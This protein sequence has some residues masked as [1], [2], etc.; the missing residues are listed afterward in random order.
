MENET[1]TELV[2]ELPV[3]IKRHDDLRDECMMHILRLS[4]KLTANYY[5][6]SVELL[7]KKYDQYGKYLGYVFPLRIDSP[8]RDRIISEGA[9]VI[10][11]FK[12]ERICN[13]K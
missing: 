8:E 13:C 11:T 7:Y 1:L 5:G 6:V 12:C 2:K 3:E 4:A 9:A 10:E